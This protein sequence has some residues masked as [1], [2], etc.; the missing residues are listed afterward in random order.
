MTRGKS[1]IWLS[2][3]A[4]L[5]ATGTALPVKAQAPQALVIQGATLIDGNGG[6]PV[7]NSVIVIQ[8]NRISAA[9]AAGQVQVPAGA[10]TIDARGKFIVPGLWDAQTNYSWFN[11]E[12]NL[13]QGVT[14]IVDIGNG[15]EWSIL[16]REAVAHGKIRGPRTV[17]GVGHLGGADPDELTG[18]ETPL[19]TRQIP[20]T[21]EETVTVSR[22]LLDAGADMIMFHDGRN[23]T[24]E[25]VAAGCR[26]AHMRGKVCTQRPD[27][28]KMKAREAARAGVDHLPHARGI[29]QDVMKDGATRTNNVLERFAQMDDAKAK[30]LIEILVRE[31]AV[32]VPALIHESPGYPRD[33]GRMEEA[34]R[35]VFT[36]PDLRAYYPDAFYKETTRVHNAVD[37]GE[38]RERRMIGYRNMLRFYKML[39]D[40][41][42]KT[43][44]GGDTNG[45]KV[46]GFV[47]HDEMEILQEAGIPAM[48][49]IQGATKWAAEAVAKQ[50]DLG[51]IERGKIADLV[52]VNADP[53]AD[54][55][56]LRNIDRV[57]FDGKVADR[58]FH[59]YYSTTFSGSVDDL[60]VVEA[61]PFTVALKAATF[62]GN[63]A[64]AR[65]PTDPI[66]SPQPAIQTIS[67]VW[68]KEG[69]A[70][71]T[72]KLTGYN[73]VRRTRVLFDGISVPWRF[74]G[75]T[76]LEVTLG[77]DLLKRPGRFEIVVNNPEPVS[78]PDWGNGI[79]NK[80]HFMV[81][82]RYDK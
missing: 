73:F 63:I 24:P 18:F 54:I 34:V 82:F 55:A 28:P 20:K 76:E 70:G 56:N 12:L 62:T 77:P 31:N 21:V 79:S 7:A 71:V 9:G 68:A 37:T 10:Q 25:M 75:P 4:A 47:I 1:G 43:V 14:S 67:P 2:C 3:F 40:A 16:H 46:A 38:V 26:E 51:S 60:R 50:A 72:L 64:N 5:L 59:A 49:V 29:D 45:Q 32:P 13:N 6:A 11:G 33:W 61:L 36:N 74:V 78:L 81:D 23:F 41:G 44:V 52:I 27:G 53:L 17:I 42:G 58:G 80:A 8:G 69:D 66:E 35:K 65:Q 48:H 15:E 30:A 39:D 19:S 57:I 22:R